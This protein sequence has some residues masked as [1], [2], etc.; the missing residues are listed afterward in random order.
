MDLEVVDP[1][2]MEMNEDVIPPDDEDVTKNDPGF[3][4]PEGSQ[5]KT[6]LTI[7]KSNLESELIRSNKDKFKSWYGID[8][9]T[10]DALEMN[11]ERKGDKLYF[12][13]SKGEILLNCKN[14]PLLSLSSISGKGAAEFRDI[15]TEAQQR[16]G[17]YKPPKKTAKQP[18]EPTVVNRPP[19]RPAAF[20]NPIFDDAQLT[21]ELTR[22][23]TDLEPIN[24]VLKAKGEVPLDTSS[25]MRASEFS[26]KKFREL[27]GLVDKVN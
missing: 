13:S 2:E 7:P 1:G 12:K 17:T 15:V 5:Q 19:L 23:L 16:L 14:K 25:L 24:A 22:K 3:S 18:L 27:N 4:R 8:N 11:L 6:S 20:D 26:T 21:A 9:E 10:F